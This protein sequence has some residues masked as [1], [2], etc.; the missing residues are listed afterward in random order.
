MKHG[1]D[2]GGGGGGD[3]ARAVI[4][5]GVRRYRRETTRLSWLFLPAFPPL[6]QPAVSERK[7]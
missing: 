7:I 3:N 6:Q 5:A 1:F 4:Y 2:N